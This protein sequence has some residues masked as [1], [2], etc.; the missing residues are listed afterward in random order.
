[1]TF[2]VGLKLGGKTFVDFSEEEF[3]LLVNKHMHSAADNDDF[4]FETAIQKVKEELI[5]KIR[6]D[7]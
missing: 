7:G 1:M 5:A 3:V 6:S 2:F 4:P